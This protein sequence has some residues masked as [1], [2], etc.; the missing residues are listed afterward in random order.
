[1]TTRAAIPATALDLDG[2]DHAIDDARQLPDTGTRTGTPLTNRWRSEVIAVRSLG[3]EPWEPSGEALER[4]SRAAAALRH[5]RDGY[6]LTFAVSAPDLALATRAT[7]STWARL[8][9]RCT[10]PDWQLSAVTVINDNAP[11]HPPGPSQRRPG[12]SQQRPLSRQPELAVDPA[13]HLTAPVTGA[14][15]TAATGR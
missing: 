15:T 5:H 4:A 6:E 10:L 12:A 7:M 1:M 2:Q 11:T 14:S 13:A 8:H 9:E 3:T